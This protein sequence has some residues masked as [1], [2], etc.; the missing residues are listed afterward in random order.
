MPG[1]NGREL[2]E[3]LLARRPNLRVL[4]MSGLRHDAIERRARLARAPA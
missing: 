1:M 4:Y 2:A 3:A